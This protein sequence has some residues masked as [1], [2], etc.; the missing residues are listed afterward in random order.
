MGYKKYTN[1]QEYQIAL[2]FINGVSSK[3]L[4]EKYGF[5]TRKSIT[6]KVK[7]FFPEDYKNIIE[8]NKISRKGYDYSFEKINNNFEAYFLGLLL[9]DGYISRETDVGIDLTDEDCIKFLSETIGKPYKAYP[10]RENEQIRYRLILTL[11]KN[12][13]QQ[14]ERL[15]LVPNK[16]KILQPPHFYPEE[17]KFIPYFIRGIID[18]DGCINKAS[19]NTWYCSIISASKDFIYFIKDILEN[20]I[21]LSDVH[22]YENNGY[23]TAY[24]AKRSNLLKIA[25]LCYD[26]PF[27][28]QRK[29]EL[30]RQTFRDYN[31]GSSIEE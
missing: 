25:Q 19:G 14:A 12:K 5:K 17:E 20:K 22:I 4:M 8:N 24:T 31:K 15:G 23:F 2:E 9:T 6:D 10:G 28:M 26:Q 30:F 29:Y 21:Y 13:I 1:E 27:G 3:E 7:K 11:G 18:G 16:S